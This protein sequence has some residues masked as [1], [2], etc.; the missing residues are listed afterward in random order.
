MILATSNKAKRLLCLNYIGQVRPEELR[1]GRADVKTLLADLLPGFQLL[2]DL[3]QLEF[4]DVTCAK[5][6]G[7]TMDLIDHAGVGLVV[8]VIPAP[9]KDIGMNILT[10][11]HYSHHPKIVTCESL[12]EA[13]RQFS[14]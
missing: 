11:F 14:L 12:A 7:Q 1:R 5:E 2:V 13:V 10:V 8:R 9:D 3:S 4:M 6:I